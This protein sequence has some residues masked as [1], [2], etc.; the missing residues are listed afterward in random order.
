[1]PRVL[2]IDDSAFFRRTV[3]SYLEEAGYDVDDFLPLSELEVME[4]AKVWNPDLVITDFSMPHVNGQSVARM[5]R[6]H[7][8]DVPI[9]VLTATRDPDREARLRTLGL[10]H[11]IYKPITGPELVE[12]VREI[13][14][15]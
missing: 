12:Q 6:R 1:M 4:R 3:R 14:A 7:S 8:K 11:V 10:I 5:I 2:V 15:P 9:L 13:K